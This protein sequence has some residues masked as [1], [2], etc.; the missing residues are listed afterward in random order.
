MTDLPKLIKKS[1]L[2][3]FCLLMLRKQNS[4][5]SNWCPTDTGSGPASI[6]Q[7]LQ[8]KGSAAPRNLIP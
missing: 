3:S 2:G 1:Y 8:H 7:K 5:I 4:L 6:G